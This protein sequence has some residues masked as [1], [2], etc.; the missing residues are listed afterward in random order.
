MAPRN[1]PKHT[2]RARHIPTSLLRGL[3]AALVPALQIPLQL[4]LQPA[5]SP[6]PALPLVEIWWRS[7]GWW[8]GWGESSSQILKKQPQQPYFSSCCCSC[9][10][11]SC[12]C[13]GGGGYWI[14]TLSSISL[15]KV[16]DFPG[17]NGKLP[18]RERSH[19]P[20]KWHFESMI[21]RTS[22]GGICIHSL[23]GMYIDPV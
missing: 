8:R 16:K 14:L 15:N 23:E 12:C 5:P 7:F 19:I 4:L 10:C 22:Q 11:C 17:A 9:S 6:P 21:F 13:G 3:L 18:S 2:R 1:H 20:Q